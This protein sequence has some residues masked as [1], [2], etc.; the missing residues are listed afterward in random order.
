MSIPVGLAVEGQMHIT[1]RLARVL[2]W[3]L[4][5]LAHLTLVVALLAFFWWLQISPTSINSWVSKFS[6]SIFGQGVGFAFWLFGV[7][8]AAAL[9]AYAKG[10]HWAISKWLTKYLFKGLGV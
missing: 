4:V 3:S 6:T 1:A 8:V 9:F 10:C 7:S 2:V 5:L